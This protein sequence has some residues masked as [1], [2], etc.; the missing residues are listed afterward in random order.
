MKKYHARTR[1]LAHMLPA[2]HGTVQ[3]VRCG[4]PELVLSWPCG[5]VLHYPLLCLAFETIAAGAAAAAAVILMHC[6]APARP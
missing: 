2:A 4:K 5:T 3:L 6:R 1:L